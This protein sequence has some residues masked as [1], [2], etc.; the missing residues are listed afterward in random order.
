MTKK[1]LFFVLL[2]ALLILAV[3]PTVSAA[4]EV[5]LTKDIY[6]YYKFDNDYTDATNNN[7]DLR[8]ISGTP[9]FSTGVL[10][11]GLYFD[12]TTDGLNSTKWGNNFTNLTISAWLK[13]TYYDRYLIYSRNGGGDSNVI[14]LR[15]VTSGDVENMSFYDGT[16]PWKKFPSSKTFFT[17]SSTTFTFITWTFNETGNASL[18]V[19]GAFNSTVAFDGVFKLEDLQ[20]G[21]YNG[22][23]GGC[24]A[25]YLGIIDEMGVWNRTLTAQDVSLLYNDGT[26]LRYPFT[27]SID[28]MLYD[29]ETNVQVDT[30]IVEL[31]GSTGTT[32]K[33]ITNENATFSNITIGEY[34]LSYISSDANRRHYYLNVSTVGIGVTYP[35]RLYLLNN[36]N[37]NT[38]IVTY[39]LT[40]ENGIGL[41]NGTVKLLRRIVEEGISSYRVV[42]MSKSDVNGKGGLTLEKYDPFYQFIVDYNGNTILTTSG[43]QIF[44]DTLIIRGSLSENVIQS[45]NTVAN[46]NSSLTYNESTG[47]FIL[48]WNDPS[49]IISNVCLN[50]TRIR[51]TGIT[52]IND[53]CLAASSG[54][55]ILG[56]GG[57]STNG[58]YRAW[59][60]IE[61]NTANSPHVIEMIEKL[62]SSVQASVGEQGAFYTALLVIVLAL[63]GLAVVRH[64]AG[65]LFGGIIGVISGGLFG[66]IDITFAA[67]IFAIVI[68]GFIIFGSRRGV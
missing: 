49:G 10:N 36:S 41:S 45:T 5:N 7:R 51:G 9:T 29:E 60:R 54:S 21:N 56:S 64:P 25:Q 52:V 33:T 31:I 27:T 6:S 20:M 3:L 30:G 63:I 24:N 26:P 37:T 61:T 65:V 16:L 47:S 68:V 19:N 42:E 35:V 15:P 62:R 34:E 38:K 46:L 59:S 13:P 4:A 48:T 14:G 28:V 40:D 32:I 50:V 39:D 67:V 1:T 22:C 11:N 18:Y 17:N 55:I 58:L 53:T 44:D 12:G 23:G 8:E 2:S 43:S 66:L 57:N